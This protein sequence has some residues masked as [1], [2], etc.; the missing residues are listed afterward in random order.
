MS[1]KKKMTLQSTGFLL[2]NCQLFLNIRIFPSLL[3]AALS[4]CLKCVAAT[5]SA[6]VS[7]SKIL[8]KLCV[9]YFN[10]YLAVTEYT[11]STAHIADP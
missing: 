2:L 6:T 5:V 11:P 10:F 7:A 9:R 4:L 3:D 1:V 8:G